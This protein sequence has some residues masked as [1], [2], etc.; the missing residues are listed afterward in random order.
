M[1]CEEGRC[2]W[3][4]CF[5]LLVFTPLLQG[6][7]SPVFEGHLTSETAVSWFYFA[8]LCTVSARCLLSCISCFV[9][10]PDSMAGSRKLSEFRVSG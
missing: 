1:G 5:L 9:P 2:E 7:E 10:A 6:F 8:M 3:S 4:G